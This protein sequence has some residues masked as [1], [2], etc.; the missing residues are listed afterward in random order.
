MYSNI[1]LTNCISILEINGP[2]KITNQI[3]ISK[4]YV[5]P[6]I[7]V[8]TSAPSTLCDAYVG[9]DAGVAQCFQYHILQMDW[10][11][12]PPRLVSIHEFNPTPD[13]IPLRFRPARDTSIITEVWALARRFLYLCVWRKVGMQ[14]LLPILRNHM[15]TRCT[16]PSS[17]IV[18]R[19]AT[20]VIERSSS[21]SA[22]NILKIKNHY[23][24][25]SVHA[26]EQKCCQI[27]SWERQ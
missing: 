2:L 18:A 20:S 17:S 15:G 25:W 10:A 12:D 3:R 24:K 7:H 9:G 16:L 22:K 8:Y 1:G 19:F 27:G 6:S 23:V 21:I 14:M 13:Q 26:A 5:S 11:I 4:H